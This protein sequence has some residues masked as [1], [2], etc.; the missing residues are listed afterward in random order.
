MYS[1]SDM[2]LKWII[3]LFVL[4]VLLV[5]GHFVPVSSKNLLDS[6]VPCGTHSE[7]QTYRYQVYFGHPFSRGGISNKAAYTNGNF[8]VKSILAAACH[9][10]AKWYIYTQHNHAKLYLW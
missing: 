7:D 5:A 8:S 4:V 6:T 2:N 1:I 10:P 3:G 9:A